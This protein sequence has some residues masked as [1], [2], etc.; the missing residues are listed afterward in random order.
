MNCAVFWVEWKKPWEATG[1]LWKYVPVL[2]EKEVVW[3]TSPI[4]F[5]VIFVQN[6]SHM[7]AEVSKWLNFEIEY[8]SYT[9]QE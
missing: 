4:D 7:L 5:L 3:N 2:Y 8:V 9:Q 1:L 6:S